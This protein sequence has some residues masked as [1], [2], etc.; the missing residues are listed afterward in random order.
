MERRKYLFPI[1]N[2]FHP[3]DSV[4]EMKWYGKGSYIS[5]LVCVFLFFIS[6]II[7]KVG[8]GFAYST[9]SGTYGVFEIFIITFG[10]FLLGVISN[11]LLCTLMDGEGKTK[12]I[13]CLI[14][15]S[16]IILTASN[17]VHTILTNV[18]QLELII[19]IQIIDV[20]F[21][22]W[23]FACLFLGL[24]TAHNFTFFKTVQ[25]IVFTI[26]A[27]ILVSFLILLL[28]SLFQQVASFVYVVYCEL[29]FRM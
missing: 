1:Y 3:I 29:V 18:L 23:F 15:Y 28:F 16:L 13:C 6:N 7:V 21:Y 8:S 4:D 25:N 12:E 24:K 26:I 14:S 19:F 17:I 22:I 2:I 27:M 9:A 5:S 20:I 10:V 11:I